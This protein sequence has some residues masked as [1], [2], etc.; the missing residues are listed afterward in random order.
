LAAIYLLL[1]ESGKVAGYANIVGP[2]TIKPDTIIIALSKTKL[3]KFIVMP[4]VAIPTHRMNVPKSAGIQE[5]NFL[6]KLLIWSSNKI[7]T[8]EYV[9]RTL[10]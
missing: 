7:R 5:G 1:T 9:I 8:T 6:T 10:L 2:L 3:P 4:N